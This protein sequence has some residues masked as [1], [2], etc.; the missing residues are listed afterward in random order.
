M[1]RL[2]GSRSTRAP[3]AAAAPDVP[4]TEPSS[5]TTTSRPGSNARSSSITRATLC[6]SFNA[7]TIATRRGS[8]RR[9]STFGGAA[10][11]TVSLTLTTVASQEDAGRAPPGGDGAVRGGDAGR[12]LEHPRVEDGGQKPRK[13]A[14]GNAS[15][16]LQRAAVPRDPGS[17]A[18]EPPPAAQLLAEPAL[19]EGEQHDAELDR[20][21]DR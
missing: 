16:L 18:C 9:E 13:L 17:V 2:K 5:I 1:P 6:S 14:V 21:Q 8:R 7:G 20:E 19:A 15:R 12:Q 4:S 11:A 3:F 10:V